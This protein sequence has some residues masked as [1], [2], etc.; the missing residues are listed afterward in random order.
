MEIKHKVLFVDHSSGNKRFVS[1]AEKNLCE[2][3]D[4]YKNIR[5]S[6]INKFIGTSYNKDMFGMV[7]YLSPDMDISKS[8]YVIVN[9]YRRVRGKRILD[10]Y[11]DSTVR[12]IS[13]FIIKNNIKIIEFNGDDISRCMTN[14]IDYI[15]LLRDKVGP[16]IEIVISDPSDSEPEKWTRITIKNDQDKKEEARYKRLS[17]L[18]LLQKERSH[19]RK[20]RNKGIYNT[21]TTK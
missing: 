9:L 2:T 3:F 10:N 16:D 6:R 13:D 12:I 8:A 15:S 11:I 5:Q 4:K 14:G 1:N 19:N 17:Q 7:E 20:H 18:E 21:P